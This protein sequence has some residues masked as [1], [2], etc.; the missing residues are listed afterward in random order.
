LLVESIN[1]PFHAGYFCIAH[2]GTASDILFVP[3][4]KVEAKL[5]ANQP[6]KISVGLIDQFRV[7]AYHLRAM[8]QV[9]LFNIDR[10]HGKP[11]ESFDFKRFPVDRGLER[12]R[13]KKWSLCIDGRLKIVTI[14]RC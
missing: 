1:I 4:L 2:L 5:A 9:D 6:Q 10:V 3:E 8:E 14:E 12:K 13:R 11:Q 7:P